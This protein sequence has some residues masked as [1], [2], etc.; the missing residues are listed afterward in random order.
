[1]PRPAAPPDLVGRVVLDRPRV[2]VVP[3]LVS[4]SA[5]PAERFRSVDAVTGGAALG[6]HGQARAAA[7]GEA[8]ERF[9]ANVVPAGLP[10]A[11]HR[12]LVRA[13]RPAAD[14]ASL[15]LYSARQHA[16]RGFP[17]VPLTRDLEIAWAAGRD[18]AD[19]GEILVPASL[20]YVNYFRGARA[21]EPPT[22]YPVLAGTAA[23][24]SLEAAR[25]AALE[26][27]LE[28]DAVTL[29]WASGARGAR[30][31]VEPRGPL[32]AAV[33]EARGAGLRVT[34][35]RVPSTFDVLVAGVFVEDPARRLVGFGS[36]CRAT[37]PEAAAKAF[38]EAIGMHETALE[39]SDGDGP[40]WRAARTDHR[41]Y[42]AYRADRA[43][44]DDFR[45]D[46]RD[47]N[48]VRLHVQVYL[49]PRMQD[50]RL[51]R[52]RD[53][54]PPLPPPSGA[55]LPHYLRVLAGRPVIGVDLSTPEAHAAGLRVV[56]VLVPG[57]TCNAPAAFPFLGG[58]RITAG[59]A[60]TA[61]VRHPLP[62]S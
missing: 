6:D 34:F 28:R 14:P 19:D 11:S 33:A 16:Q 53:P 24:T 52:M 38:T 26:E 17:F 45:P 4:Y 60:E 61:L 48:D 2:P 57:L 43:Y 23:A 55:G 40:F 5:H 39:L 10:V 15:A 32:A 54:G 46:W 62:F 51:D 25:C 47:V 22:N 8:V 3:S 49:D 29:W 1:M 50:A 56:R 41:P 44:L 9:C 27:V 42:R 35:L 30:L 20:A 31:G 37:A 58:D 36:A 18:L 13:G 7:V 12:A 59:R 21:A